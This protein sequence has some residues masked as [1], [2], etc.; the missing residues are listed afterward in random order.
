M[1]PVTIITSALIAGATALSKGVLS[2][3][4]KDAYAN[5]KTA[6]KKIFA[7]KDNEEG[8]MALAKI[9][10]PQKAET[11]QPIL[12]EAIHETEADKDQNILD[13]VNALTKVMHASPETSQIMKQYNITHSKIG[14][15]GDYAQI[16][17]GIHMG[18]E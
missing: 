13:A 7:E 5:L 15:M 2:Q 3:A 17:G 1:E 8:N 16:H 9:S 4:G 18:T 10:N 12:D 14:H 6:V 11:W